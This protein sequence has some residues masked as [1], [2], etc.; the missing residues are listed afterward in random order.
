M[1]LYQLFPLIFAEQNLWNMLQERG[2][3]HKN[4]PEPF[5]QVYVPP[6]GSVKFGSKFG[7]DFFDAND[8]WKKAEELGIIDSDSDDDTLNQLNKVVPGNSRSKPSRTPS[9]IWQSKSPQITKAENSVEAVTPTTECPP[10]DGSTRREH[11]NTTLHGQHGTMT[12][13]SMSTCTSLIQH[14]AELGNSGHFIRDL[15][16][17]LWDCLSNKQGH[18]EKELSWRYCRATRRGSGNLGRDHW[19]CPPNSNGSKGIFGKD[20]FTTEEAVLAHVLRQLKSFDEFAQ[21]FRENDDIINDIEIR[22]SRAIEQHMS[23]SEVKT[24]AVSGRRKSNKENIAQTSSKIPSPANQ[25]ADDQISTTSFDTSTS[26]VKQGHKRSTTNNPVNLTDGNNTENCKE[27]F[28]SS[29]RTVEGAEILLELNKAKGNLDEEEDPLYDNRITTRGVKELLKFRRRAAS[30]RKS[31]QS[32]GSESSLKRLRVS[33]SATCH[34]TQ[35]PEDSEIQSFARSPQ[36]KRLKNSHKNLPLSGLFF[37]GS[38]VKDDAKRTVRELGGSFLDD[39]Q[40]FL[41]QNKTKLKLFFLSH[42]GNRRTHKYI[43]AGALGVP[44]LNVDWVYSLRDDYEDFKKNDSCK[45]MPDAFNNRRY[46]RHR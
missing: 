5:N 27:K 43:L 39:L 25:V 28:Q 31:V 26:T 24:T 34:L 42:V 4:G 19:F 29:Q 7:V 10:I 41:S 3:K 14:F 15:F 6:G 30:K 44:M 23:Y 40:R 45:K 38:G 35:A 13:S 17:P 33:P 37:F 22:L 12:M 9:P 36:V 16:S 11:D 32:H 2:W 21:I 8:L 46:I 18:F 1:N 20:Y